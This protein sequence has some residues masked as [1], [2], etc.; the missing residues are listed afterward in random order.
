MGGSASGQTDI[1]SILGG[2]GSATNGTA[3]PT[4]AMVL[5][6]PRKAKWLFKIVD[7]LDS[8]KEKADPIAA[9][10]VILDPLKDELSMLGQISQFVSQLPSVANSE[11][12]SQ[13]PSLATSQKGSPNASRDKSPRSSKE[14][15]F[16]SQHTSVKGV[17][18]ADKLEMVVE[19]PS[20][21]QNSSLRGGTFMS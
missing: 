9:L 11:K 3:T 5:Q 16:V 20:I 13:V 19:S 1:S 2:N 6:D 7:Q 21:S 18:Q 10:N 4:T 12:V 17:E 8:I 14:E 15:M